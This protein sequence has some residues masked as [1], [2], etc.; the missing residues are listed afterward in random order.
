MGQFLLDVVY[1]A[2]GIA[3]YH[4]GKWVVLK[5]VKKSRG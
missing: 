1:V 2:I 5:L 3:I 4:A